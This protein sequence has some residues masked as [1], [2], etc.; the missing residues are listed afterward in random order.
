MT[1]D[2]LTVDLAATRQC[3]SQQARFTQATIVIGL[4]R[5]V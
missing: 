4:L 3:G 1:V 2:T 5:G